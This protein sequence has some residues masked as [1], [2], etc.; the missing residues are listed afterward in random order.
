MPKGGARP[1]AGR[2]KGARNKRTAALI[3]KVEAGGKTPLEIMLEAARE[4][5]AV[6]VAITEPLVLLKKEG[7]KGLA[8]IV[9]RLGLMQQAS[10]LA[11]SAAPYVHPRLAA[12]EHTGKGGT[13]LMPPALYI[14]AVTPGSIG[15]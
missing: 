4:H 15:K 12:I 13:Q 10:S 14:V 8:K 3:A 6:A 7:D 11:S 2:K 1:G 9:D 5:Y